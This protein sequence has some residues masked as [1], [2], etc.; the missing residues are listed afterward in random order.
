MIGAT[1]N[2]IIG[3]PASLQQVGADEDDFHAFKRV[4]TQ[5]TSEE[6]AERRKSGMLERQKVASAKANAP[7]SSVIPRSNVPIKKAKVVAF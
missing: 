6:K 5:L 4:S 2:A 1:S 3:L 7:S